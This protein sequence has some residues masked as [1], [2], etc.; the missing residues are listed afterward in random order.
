MVNNITGAIVNQDVAIPV[1]IDIL[2]PTNTVNKLTA[3]VKTNPLL[4]AGIAYGAYYFFT[5][6]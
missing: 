1:D 6:K 3:F 4:S 5:K 2:N